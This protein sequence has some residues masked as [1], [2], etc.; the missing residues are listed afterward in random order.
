MGVVTSDSSHSAWSVASLC[1]GSCCSQQTSKSKHGDG[2]VTMDVQ[3]FRIAYVDG[4]AIEILL[5]KIKTDVQWCIKY[6]IC[7]WWRI[8][9]IL[10]N[11]AYCQPLFQL[12][13]THGLLLAQPMLHDATIYKSMQVR[14]WMLLYCQPTKMVAANSKMQV[15]ES[16]G[17]T[18]NCMIWLMTI[19]KQDTTYTYIVI[20]QLEPFLD[21]FCSLT[22]PDSPN[23]T[24]CNKK[25][26]DSCHS[27]SQALAK[28]L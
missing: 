13:V 7:T 8:H 23:R 28:Q 17:S 20:D 18:P 19:R 21:H 16:F 1:L 11:S 5:P 14:L 6:I 27:D 2:L 12:W 3:Q 9:V 4:W 25:K 10:L 26:R 24:S 15:W 22:S